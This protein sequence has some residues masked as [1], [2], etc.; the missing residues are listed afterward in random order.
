MTPSTVS[1]KD[2]VIV[3]ATVPAWME[4]EGAV[5]EFAG[6]V[7]SNVRPPVANWIAGS[8]TPVPLG[9]KVRVNTPVI[10]TG[11]PLC[12]WRLMLGCWPDEVVAGALRVALSGGAVTVK[13]WGR[14]TCTG[15]ELD[16]V[17]FSVPNVRRS[18]AGMLAVNEVELTNVVGSAVPLTWITE[19]LVKPLPETE[20]G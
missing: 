9:V 20:I 8:S 13:L 16:T 11:Y 7:K 4:T 19:P 5:V 18:A 6:M 12:N 1:A 3:P 10:A 2:I 14:L 15:D 17:M